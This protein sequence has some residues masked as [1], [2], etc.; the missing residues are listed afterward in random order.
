MI[1]DITSAPT[2][3]ACSHEPEATICHPTVSEYTNP[4]QAAPTSNPHAFDAPILA[5]SVHA[6][7][8]KIVSGVVV[9]NTM[10]PMSSGVSP[11]PCVR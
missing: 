2:T 10:S 8:G 7:L 9:P 1:D 5:C 4:E 6:A 3:S 11:A